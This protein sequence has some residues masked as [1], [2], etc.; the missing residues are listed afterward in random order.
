[1]IGLITIL[2]ADVALCSLISVKYLIL[3]LIFIQAC[4]WPVQTRMEQGYFYWHRASNSCLRST[5]LCVAGVRGLF[6]CLARCYKM[7]TFINSYLNFFISLSKVVFINKKT[8]VHVEGKSAASPEN[9]F[10]SSSANIHTSQFATAISLRSCKP[11]TN[12]F[13]SWTP[14]HRLTELDNL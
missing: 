10:F 12:V 11:E 6:K 9:D 1:M 3:D 13:S 14:S 4:D 7:S 2:T 8:L 5:L